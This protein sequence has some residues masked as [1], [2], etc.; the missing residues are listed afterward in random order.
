MARGRTTKMGLAVG[1]F[2]GGEIKGE[3][4]VANGSSSTMAVMDG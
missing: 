1:V 4:G 3:R 2:G